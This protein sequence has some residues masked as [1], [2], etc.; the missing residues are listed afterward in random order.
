MCSCIY[1]SVRF[2]LSTCF[3]QKVLSGKSI[4]L[5]SV[6]WIFSNYCKILLIG[7]T[8][9]PTLVGMLTSVNNSPPTAIDPRMRT[10]FSVWC[11]VK[12]NILRI[13][14]RDSFDIIQTYLILL[15]NNADIICMKHLWKVTFYNIHYI[16]VPVLQFNRHS[17]S[18]LRNLFSQVYTL[19]FNCDCILYQQ[20]YFKT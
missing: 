18:C 1:Q 13:I 16:R 19:S 12:A 8:C 11:E 4:F 6:G 9:E 14:D 7:R 20:K 17:Y 5:L 10:Y 15:P 3:C 2:Q